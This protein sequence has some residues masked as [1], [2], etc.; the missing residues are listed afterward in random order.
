IIFFCD[1]PPEQ[2]NGG[3]SVICDVR[4]TLSKLDPEI[5]DKFDRLGIQYRLYISSSGKYKSI[6]NVFGTTDKV[7]IQKFMEDRGYGHT[8]END[9]S[10]YYWSTLPAF[11]THP[12]TK[13]RVWFNSASLGHASFFRDHPCYAGMDIPDDKLPYTC[14]YG[15][16]SEIETET[17]RHIRDVMW[18]STVGFQMEKGEVLVYD[19]IYS[20]HGRIGY[21]GERKMYVTL[22]TN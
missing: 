1:V 14:Y 17:L 11:R 21:T 5:V 10:L 8:W 7:I 22:I 2:G 15:D 13:E 18:Q 9:G 12:K 3:E 20:Q 4:E 19:N 16:G 6:Q